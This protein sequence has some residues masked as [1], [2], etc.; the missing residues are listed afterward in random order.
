VYH[1]TKQQPRLI[2]GQLEFAL[3]LL[4]CL[5][6]AREHGEYIAG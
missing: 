2:C 6:A 3:H 4:G 1:L 5:V